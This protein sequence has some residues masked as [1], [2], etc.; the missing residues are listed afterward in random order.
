M[1]VAAFHVAAVVAR[2]GESGRDEDMVDAEVGDDPGLVQGLH[3]RALPDQPGDQRHHRG[4][5][6][7]PPPAIY[8]QRQQRHR[9]E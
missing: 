9:R 1:L 5:G 7:Q 8:G 2:Q 6:H 4:A 3:H